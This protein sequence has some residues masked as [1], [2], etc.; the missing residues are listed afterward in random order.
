LRRP[1][2]SARDIGQ[3]KRPSEEGRRDTVAQLYSFCFKLWWTKH[4]SKLN[5]HGSKYTTTVVHVAGITSMY[6]EVR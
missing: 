2:F 5:V 1:M 3:V 6:V 4:K